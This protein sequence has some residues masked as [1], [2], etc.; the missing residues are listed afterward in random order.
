M[1][2]LGPA[3]S[4]AQQVKLEYKWGG[5]NRTFLPAFHFLIQP[6]AEVDEPK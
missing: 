3:A 6:P 4:V 5:H 1:N 2:I